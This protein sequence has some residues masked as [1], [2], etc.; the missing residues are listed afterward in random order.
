M[1]VID[2][3]PMNRSTTINKAKFIININRKI[4]KNEIRV[5]A[6]LINMTISRTNKIKNSILDNVQN[7]AEIMNTRRQKNHFLREY[8]AP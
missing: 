2:G 5:I 7:D 1:N 8:F 6:E 4:N 3:N